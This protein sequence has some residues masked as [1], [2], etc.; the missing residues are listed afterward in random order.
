MP[1]LAFIQH[2]LY[3]VVFQYAVWGAGLLKGV[4]AELL[5]TVLHF[6]PHPVSERE[7][8]AKEIVKFGWGGNRGSSSIIIRSSQ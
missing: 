6:K 3:R 7:C 5:T 4:E 1:A 2:G 8:G